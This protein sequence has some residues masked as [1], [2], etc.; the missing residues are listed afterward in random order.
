MTRRKRQLHD[1]RGL[2]AAIVDSSDDAIISKDLKGNV[3][4]WN[5]AAEQMLGYTAEDMIGQPISTIAPPERKHEMKDILERI[6]RGERVDHFETQRRHKDGTLIDISLTV[7]PIY[8]AAGRIVGASKIARDIGERRRAD[9]RMQLLMRELDHRAKNILA[10]AQAM[11]RLTRADTVA[12]YASAVEG[13]IRALARV[14]S[15]VA[16]NRWDGADLGGLVAADFEMFPEPQKRVAMQGEA[17]WISPE[18]AQVVAILLHELSTN[19]A[20]H[21]A[22][23]SQ[24]G[25]VAVDW[26]RDADGDL[27]L[28]WREHGGPPVTPPTRR[29][30]GTQI[31]ERSVS[32]QLGGEA[33]IE[34]LPEGVSCKFVI[35][36]AHIVRMDRRQPA[37]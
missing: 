30:F 35:P 3:T 36:A 21:G 8:D 11:L 31:V 25:K 4:S 13:R 7:S 6:I 19:A 29:G 20:R 37:A 27:H 9:A 5:T 15:R 23:S 14:H 16:E 34:W 1:E 32:D 18:A 12:E 2:L 28:T 33:I 10:I 17:V 24:D 22:L 26:S